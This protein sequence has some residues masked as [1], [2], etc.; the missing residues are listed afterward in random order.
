VRRPAPLPPSGYRSHRGL[1]S[2]HHCA[3]PSSRAFRLPFKVSQA[4][5][6]ILLVEFTLSDLG[7]AN[8]SLRSSEPPF[9]PVCE[10]PSHPLMGLDSAPEY[11]PRQTADRQHPLLEFF[12]PSALEASGSDRHRVCLARLCYAFRLSQPLDVFFLPKPSRFYFTPET[13]LGFSLQRFV[14]PAWP[15]GPLGPTAPLD[16]VRTRAS[17]TTERPSRLRLPADSWQAPDHMTRTWCSGARH[18]LALAPTGSRICPQGPAQTQKPPRFTVAL[19]N[20]LVHSG[21]G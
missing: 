18:T 4:I 3:P 7:L 9:A 10:T 19:E 1:A 21:D 6:R 17:R 20:I 11:D 12:D 16:V 2:T 8:G 5:R 15:P 14:P 13:P